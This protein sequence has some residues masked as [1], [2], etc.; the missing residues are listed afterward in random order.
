MKSKLLDEHAGER[1]FALVFDTGDTVMQ[2][3]AGFLREKDVTAA[4]FSGIGAFQAVT[5]GYFDWEA[6]DYER[7]PI[8]EQVE[9]VSLTGDVALKDD[10][11]QI[12]AHVV[13]AKRDAS[14]HGGHL[15]DG[16]VRPTLEVLLID[17]P[18]HLCKRF[19][20]QTGLALIAPE[21]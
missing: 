6:K 10:E 7:I 19:D 16:T 11:P 4:R 1:T 15:L 8:D 3:L 21:L 2:P 17:A 5:L 12:H 18:K 13:I 14:A 20:P 9:V